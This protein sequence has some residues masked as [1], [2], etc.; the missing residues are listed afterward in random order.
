MTLCPLPHR[1]VGISCRA[2]RISLFDAALSIDYVCV[3]HR[4]SPMWRATRGEFAVSFNEETIPNV[5]ADTDEVRGGG[6]EIYPHFLSS[7]ALQ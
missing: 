3:H 2:M 7:S 5:W 4:S 1:C 6:H